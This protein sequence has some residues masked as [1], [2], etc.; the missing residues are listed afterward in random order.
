MVCIKII[1]ND[2]MD[3][4]FIAEHGLSLALYTDSGLTLFDVGQGGAL[5]HNAQAAGVELS[6]VFRLA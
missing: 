2:V 4:P 1:V 6:A 5:V 3:V